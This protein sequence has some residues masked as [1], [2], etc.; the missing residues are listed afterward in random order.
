MNSYPIF[1]LNINGFYCGFL[2]AF[3]EEEVKS[4]VE[5]IVLSTSSTSVL[6]KKPDCAPLWLPQ[7]QKATCTGFDC[8]ELEYSRLQFFELLNKTVSS[9]STQYTVYYNLQK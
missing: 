4:V 8:S 3:N 6:C 9:R 7:W 2:V 5:F 1:I